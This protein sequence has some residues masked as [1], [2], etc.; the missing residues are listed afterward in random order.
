MASFTAYW[1]NTAL[2]DVLEKSVAAPASGESLR[3]LRC[4]SRDMHRSGREPYRIICAKCGAN[5]FAVM[6]LVPVPPGDR[7]ESPVELDS[8][9]EHPRTT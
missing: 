3:C 8:A 1:S 5:Y 4:S 6:Q 9:G 7:P 2:S